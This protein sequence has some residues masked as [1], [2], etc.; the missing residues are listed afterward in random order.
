MTKHR[1]LNAVSLKPKSKRTSQQEQA[2]WRSPLQTGIMVSD[3][4]FIVLFCNNPCVKCSFTIEK[5]HLHCWVFQPFRYSWPV[6]ENFAI[7][8]KQLC[9]VAVRA[10]GFFFLLFLWRVCGTHSQPPGFSERVWKRDCKDVFQ[11][12]LIEQAGARAKAC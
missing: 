9:W 11:E 8:L 10:V 12:A 4:F 1:G 2:F 7:W 3:L 5:N 6:S